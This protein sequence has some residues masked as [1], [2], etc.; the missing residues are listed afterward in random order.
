MALNFESLLPAPTAKDVNNPIDL[1]GIDGSVN[2]D[3]TSTGTAAQPTALSQDVLGAATPFQLLN[4]A[5]N[6]T[7]LQGGGNLG[8]SPGN[9][10]LNALADS[11]FLNRGG[12]VGTSEQ[13]NTRDLDPEAIAAM[14]A[15]LANAAQ[16]AQGGVGPGAAAGLTPGAAQEAVGLQQGAA[17]GLAQQATP[18]QP[19]QP[20]EGTTAQPAD[21][22]FDTAEERRA[23]LAEL[24]GLD[25]GA[26]PLDIVTALNGVRAQQQID[27]AQAGQVTGGGGG[28]GAISGDG[29]RTDLFNRDQGFFDFGQG[30]V[31]RTG[32]ET[33]DQGFFDFGQ[34][35]GGGGGLGIDPLSIAAAGGG[36]GAAALL[37]RSLLGSGGGGAAVPSSAGLIGRAAP[38]RAGATFADQ[39]NPLTGQPRAQ[40]LANQG[41]AR[42]SLSPQALSAGR[43]Q[44]ALGHNVRNVV[45]NAVRAG[46]APFRFSGFRFG[47]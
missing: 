43:I 19:A 45:L 34:G 4:A 5:R 21:Q 47:R 6:L 33:G 14:I 9:D 26:D 37:L 20:A 25:P 3:Q 28:G 27:K 35:G 24:L 10:L 46:R 13:F 40:G 32:L 7:T 16:Q 11:G 22:P 39:A 8:S 15:A 36:A 29:T 1:R 17:V 2:F 18:A 41:A 42:T 23:S 31:A 44:G 12:T 30:G 38:Q